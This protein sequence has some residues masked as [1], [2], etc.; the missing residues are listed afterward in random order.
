ML[1]ITKPYGS[2]PKD[3][4]EPLVG[5]TWLFEEISVVIVTF[6]DHMTTALHELGLD[7]NIKKIKLTDDDLQLVFDLGLYGPEEVPT[8]IYRLTIDA[9]DLADI[10]MKSPVV[11]ASIIKRARSKEKAWERT[12]HYQASS[13]RNVYAVD[14][15]LK[16]IW[17]DAAEWMDG[18]REP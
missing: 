16:W 7:A 13:K 17:D 14:D 3:P 5:Y 10:Y 6:I 8:P 11:K 1:E 9:P 4:F 18:Q 12:V 15:G 2:D